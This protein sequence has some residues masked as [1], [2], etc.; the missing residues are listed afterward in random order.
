MYS[1]ISPVFSGSAV[2]HYVL[3]LTPLCWRL[4]AITVSNSDDA[5]DKMEDANEIWIFVKICQ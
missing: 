2:S 5:T 3:K 1:T 4:Y